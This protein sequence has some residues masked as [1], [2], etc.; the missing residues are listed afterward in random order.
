M[1]KM[2]CHYCGKEIK[3]GRN[4]QMEFSLTD[5]LYY[6]EGIPKGHKS[7]GWFDVGRGCFIVLNQ[8]HNNKDIQPSFDPF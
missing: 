6:A 3:E 7:Q 5:G 2:Y 8:Q 1:K 4:V